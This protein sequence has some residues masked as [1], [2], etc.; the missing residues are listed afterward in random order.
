MFIGSIK[1]EVI[2]RGMSDSNVQVN[3][4]CGKCGAPL[5]SNVLFCTK[6]GSAVTQPN[7]SAPSQQTDWR[8]QRRQWR[9]QRRAERYRSPS[10]G[11]GALIIAS[12]LV[13]AG[14]AVFFPS[15]P[16]QVF[17]GSILIL[18]GLWIVGVWLLR[19]RAHT[20]SPQQQQPQN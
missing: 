15:L 19:G 9:A 2:K 11:I 12:I 17:W 5:Q 20:S 4:F 7:P 13:V 6:C 16:W 3:R 10:R 18:L 8:E 14:L 1:R